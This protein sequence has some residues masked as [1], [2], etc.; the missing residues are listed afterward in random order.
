MSG[1]LRAFDADSGEVIWS[2]DTVR[3]FET[4]NGAKGRG[5]ALDASGPVVVDGWVYVVSG[6]SKWGGLPGNVLLGFAP[7]DT[8][9]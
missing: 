8:T 1:H 4:V 5:G 9:K 2:Y 7:K 6:Y 3:E